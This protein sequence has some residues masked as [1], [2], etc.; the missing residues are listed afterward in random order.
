MDRDSD[1]LPVANVTASGIASASASGYMAQLEA[2]AKHKK[3]PRPG[4]ASSSDSVSGLVCP[5]SGE[6]SEDHGV[7][8]F[9][10]VR[11]VGFKF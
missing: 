1:T 3:R 9:K 11:E 10:R 7:G 6:E 8:S 5:Q 4:P 2:E